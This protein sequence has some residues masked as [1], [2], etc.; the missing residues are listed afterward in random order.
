MR[1][2]LS[3]TTLICALVALLP[4]VSYAQLDAAA[5]ARAQRE[6]QGTDIYGNP[7]QNNMMVSIILRNNGHILFDIVELIFQKVEYHRK[8]I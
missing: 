2:F 8:H 5:L 1:R 3:I 6:G 7:I 4:E